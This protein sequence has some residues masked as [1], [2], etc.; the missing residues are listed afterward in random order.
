MSFRT[1]Y[2]MFLGDAPDELAA[3]T[4][5][6][7]RDWRPEWCVGQMRLADCKADLNLPEM[8]IEDAKAAGCGTMIV[9]VANRGG[10]ISDSWGR[11]DRA[12]D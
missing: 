6:G 8:S 1:P 10:L 11:C 7:V 3:K 4:A 2:L 9:G 12:G 5:I